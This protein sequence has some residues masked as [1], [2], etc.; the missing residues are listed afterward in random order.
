MSVSLQSLKPL[1][2]DFDGRRKEKYYYN[3]IKYIAVVKAIELLETVIS[4]R[5]TI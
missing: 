2:A 5:A 4:Y 1:A 3:S